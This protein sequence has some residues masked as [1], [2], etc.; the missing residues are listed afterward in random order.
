MIEDLEMRIGDPTKGLPDDVFLFLTRVTPMINVDLLIRDEGGRSLL[1]WRDDGYHAPGWHIP[2][3]IIR[4]KETFEERI[5]AVALQELGTRV[6]FSPEPIAVNQVIHPTRKNR[7]HFISLLYACS[8]QAPPA[9]ALAF[10][11]EAP[12]PGQWAWHEMCPEDLIPVHQMY[13][14]YLQVE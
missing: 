6:S 10:C 2:G 7:G 5:R 8:L 11:G 3:G 1:T 9:Q 12:R 13:R 14:K 4:F